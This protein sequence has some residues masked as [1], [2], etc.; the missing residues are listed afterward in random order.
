M[1]IKI[2]VQTGSLDAAS[3]L[4]GYLLG[5]GVK[6]SIAGCDV[7]VVV[8]IGDGDLACAHIYEFH[9]YYRPAPQ[10]SPAQI[11]DE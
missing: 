6:T 8:P 11:G 1:N 5:K 3:F 2:S 9:R 10:A 7:E 4:C